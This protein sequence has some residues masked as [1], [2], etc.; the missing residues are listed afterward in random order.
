MKMPEYQ[1]GTK[2]KK[3]LI[4]AVNLHKEQRKKGSG[5]PYFSHLIGVA[6][7]VLENDGDEGQAI[8]MLLHDAVEDQGGKPVL[9][10]IRADFGDRV[11]DIVGCCT[12]ID[13]Q[14]WRE[15]KEAHLHHIAHAS[16][17][18]LKV[19]LADKLHNVR[20]ILM[21]RRRYGADIWERLHGGR[22]GKLWYYREVANSLC[23][24]APGIMADELA[25]TVTEL[26]KLES[27]RQATKPKLKL[28]D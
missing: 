5:A 12:D 11:A 26:E 1:L 19:A 15:R 20:S 7:L 10:R 21:D 24:H 14:I 27:S 23:K 13:S 28:I 4:L 2:F 16:A 22:D 3:A 9:D 8:A 6:A 17:D 25:R 18:V